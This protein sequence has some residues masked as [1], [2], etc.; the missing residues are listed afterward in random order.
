M[1]VDFFSDPGDGLIISNVVEGSKLVVRYSTEND[2][3]KLALYINGV[4]TMDLLLPTTRSYHTFATEVFDVYI[5]E[6]AEIKIQLDEEEI[7]TGAN[8]DYIEIIKIN[9]TGVKLNTNSLNLIVGETGQL[10]ATVIPD[11]ATNK[12]VKF[13]SSNTGIA[14]VDDAGKVTAVAEGTAT[15][16]VTTVDGSLTASCVVNVTKEASESGYIVTTIFMP[17][18]LQGNKLISADVNVENIDAPDDPVLAIV[19]LYDANNRMINVS[20]ISKVIAKGK[21]EKLSAGFILPED[22]T[23]HCVKVFVW[24]GETPATSDG[25]PLSNVV[26]LSATEPTN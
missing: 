2:P 19:A 7:E 11:N 17:A 12:A 14:T 5:P 9:V 24:D 10:T 26:S 25:R 15:I 6:G 16:T 4:Y 20:Y 1:V 3:G 8:I 13:S 18:T 23:G 22:I 21:V